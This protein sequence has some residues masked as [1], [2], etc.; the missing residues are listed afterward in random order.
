MLTMLLWCWR[1]YVSQEAAL[2]SLVNVLCDQIASIGS[3]IAV[4]L[5]TANGLGRDISLLTEGQI[6][7]YQKVSMA[8]NST[9][10]IRICY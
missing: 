5:Q 8:L 7:A 4:S 9:I 2:M 1:W 6:V 10:I 3:G